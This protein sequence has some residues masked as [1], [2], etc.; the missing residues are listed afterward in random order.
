MSAAHPT[1]LASGMVGC[2]QCGLAMQAP[3]TGQYAYCPRCGSSVHGRKPNSLARSWAFLLTA[4]ILYIPS[5]LYPV[6]VISQFGQPSKETIISGVV[7]LAESGMWPLAALVFTA[8][9]FVPLLK[10]FS[11]TLLLASVKLRW[12]KAALQRSRL[13]RYV[14]FIGRWSMLDIFMISILGAL[15]NLGP[16]ITIT[17][18]FG[19]VCFA[20]VVVSTMLASETFDPRLIWDL[21]PRQ[22]ASEAPQSQGD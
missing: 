11:L 9:I 14:E 6:M 22:T 10:I 16:L 7:E 12:T 15:V 4:V 8:S 3:E 1:S 20:G 21:S 5:N 2:H 13:Y 19:A 18:G 17:A